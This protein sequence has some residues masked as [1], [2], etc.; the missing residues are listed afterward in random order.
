MAIKLSRTFILRKM[1]QVTGIA[2]LGLFLLEHFYTNSKALISPDAFNKAVVELQATP[3]II[4]LEIFGIALPLLYHAV[5][6]M[7]I[8]FDMKPN[9]LSYA[10]GR[11]WFYT[12][13]RVTGIILFFFILFHVL[14]FRFGWIPGL[15]QMSVAQHPEKSYKIVSDEF[16]KTWIFAIYIVGITSTV[17]HFANGLWLF[18]VDW[19]V[20]I[21]EKAQRASAYACLAFGAALLAVGINAAAAFVSPGGLFSNFG[22]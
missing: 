20:T 16:N 6:G 18:L 15:N 3:Y 10:Y 7:F 9:N 2:P 1:H 13:Q 19:G 11:N 14:N 17:F 22:F 8:T 12:L 4:L 5:Y 21:G